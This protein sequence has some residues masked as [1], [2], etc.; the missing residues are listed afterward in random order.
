MDALKRSSKILAR[1][2]TGVTFSLINGPRYFSVSS[3]NPY[4]VRKGQFIP[5]TSMLSRM[6]VRSQSTQTSPAS[7]SVVSPDEEFQTLDI[8]RSRSSRFQRQRKKR[9]KKEVPPP[10]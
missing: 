2:G 9:E 7:A 8:I 5:S 4:A 3:V 10:R 6:V 1:F